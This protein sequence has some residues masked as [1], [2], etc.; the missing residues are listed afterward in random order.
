MFSSYG[1]YLNDIFFGI[2]NEGRLYI[3]TNNVTRKKFEAYGMQPFA[4]SKK[5]VL[6]NY[7][8]VPI[9]VIE[10]LFKLKNWILESVRTTHIS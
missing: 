6:K 4:P 2:V 3:K 7:Y 10:D 5:Q 9:E 1:L 8:E